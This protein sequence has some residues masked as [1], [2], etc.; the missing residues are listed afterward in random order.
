M[1]KENET[2]E[3]NTVENLYSSSVTYAV[4]SQRYFTHA[5]FE[6]ILRRLTILFRSLHLNILCASR[7]TFPRARFYLSARALISRHLTSRS[8]L[9]EWSEIYYICQSDKYI[10]RCIYIAALPPTPT[11][12]NIL[13]KFPVIK[14]LEK[15]FSKNIDELFIRYELS[16]RNLMKN[17]KINGVPIPPPSNGLIQKIS[18]NSS[19]FFEARAIS[20]H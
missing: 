17:L 18:N 9:R 13:N 11:K 3:E 19:S 16:E 12:I 10:C 2:D 5:P 8:F 1:T 6:L 20:L 7:R 15:I 14:Q 4:G